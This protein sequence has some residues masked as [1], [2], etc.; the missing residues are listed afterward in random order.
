MAPSLAGQLAPFE[1]PVSNSPHPVP[2]LREDAAVERMGLIKLP[3]LFYI[4]AALGRA[5]VLYRRFDGD[6][7]V[8][9]PA[10]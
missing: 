1:Q 5:S 4:D 10:G 8:I 6:L 2:C 9:T 7:T 3:F